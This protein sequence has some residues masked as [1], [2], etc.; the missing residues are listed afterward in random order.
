MITVVYSPGYQE[1]FLNGN[2]CGQRNMTIAISN[3]KDLTIGRAL[4][5]D[6]FFNGKID[7]AVI[8]KKALNQEEIIDV[9]NDGLAR[10][11]LTGDSIGDVCD[12]CWYSINPDQMDS[13]MDCSMPPYTFDPMC[14][15]ACQETNNPPV[16]EDIPD[17]MVRVNR[18]LYLD[19]EAYD[20][21]NDTLIYGT[22]AQQVLPGDVMFDQYTGEFSWYAS[23]LGNYTVNF[24]VTDGQDSDE[25]S[26]LIKVVDILR[27]FTTPFKANISD[28]LNNTNASSLDGLLP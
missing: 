23:I 21:D 13:N 24:N 2:A 1:I 18:T 28:I 12:N 5:V 19:I 10:H 6:E 27:A 26:I 4:G 16:L 22:D 15:D 9:F 3:D 25:Q 20:Q 11:L 17:K 8:Y 7:E 14:G